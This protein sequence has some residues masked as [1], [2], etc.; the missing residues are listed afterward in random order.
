MKIRKVW[1]GLIVLLIVFMCL[2][3]GYG[4]YES[5]L[6]AD[7]YVRIYVK[8]AKVE[9]DET[10]NSEV[11]T[12]GDLNVKL[13]TFKI[14]PVEEGDRSGTIYVDEDGNETVEEY[15]RRIEVGVELSYKDKVLLEPYFDYILYD[16]DNKIVGS[17]GVRD[18]Y[19]DAF[20]KEKYG[21]NDYSQFNLNGEHRAGNGGACFYEGKNDDP[22]H[23][24]KYSH[25]DIYND[26]EPTNMYYLRIYNIKYRVEGSSEYITHDN[27]MIEFVL[28]R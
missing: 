10:I 27:E 19:F 5:I 17:N 3:L 26:Y 21:I 15:L 18:K 4:V 14:V 25:W 12:L 9:D 20:L 11:A 24:E 7:E 13:S 28:E 22:L 16:E 8:N 1:F 2:V 23:I 6:K